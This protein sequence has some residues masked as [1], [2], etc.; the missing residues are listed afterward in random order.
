MDTLVTMLPIAFANALVE[1]NNMLSIHPFLGDYRDSCVEQ[2]VPCCTST[3][4][5]EGVAATTDGTIFRWPFKRAKFIFDDVV[6]NGPICPPLTNSMTF[7]KCHIEK[8]ITKI[9]HY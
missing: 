8:R 1:N 5:C 7:A 2:R 6:V 3:T 9:I 4:G